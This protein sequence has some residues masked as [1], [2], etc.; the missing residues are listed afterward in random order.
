[1]S[2]HPM[3]WPLELWP[4]LREATGADLV[5]VAS[6]R[7]PDDVLPDGITH[8]GMMSKDDYARML[9]SSLNVPSWPSV[10]QAECSCPRSQRPR[11]CSAFP[12][13]RYHLVL[14]SLC[15]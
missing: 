11:S 3:T 9:V 10:K 4:A 15:E 5:S 12:T 8:L 2:V 14:T 1:M 6:P 7:Q 13:R